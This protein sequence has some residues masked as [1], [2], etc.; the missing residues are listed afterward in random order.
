MEKKKF[1]NQEKHFIMSDFIRHWNKV[2]RAQLDINTEDCG[3]N[4]IFVKIFLRTEISFLLKEL[5]E[6]HNEIYSGI[7]SE[8]GTE[9][10]GIIQYTYV[11]TDYGKEL[12]TCYCFHF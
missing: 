11:D 4:R 3:E 9:Q 8:I 2:K 1:T 5:N 6:L 10:M 12:K 7:I